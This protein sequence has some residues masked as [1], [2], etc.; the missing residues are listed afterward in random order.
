MPGAAHR[1]IYYMNKNYY[2]GPGEEEDDEGTTVA[3]ETGTDEA[4]S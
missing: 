3:T 1:T 4:A 2:N